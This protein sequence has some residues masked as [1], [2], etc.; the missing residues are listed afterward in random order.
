MSR[1][2]LIL[3]GTLASFSL[4]VACSNMPDASADA[5]AT[6]VSAELT[7]C[8]DRPS[9]VSSAAITPEQFIEPLQFSDSRKSAQERLRQ[10][11]QR[12]ARS[13]ITLDKPGYMVVTVKSEIFGFTDDMEFLFDA[14]KNVVHFRSGARMGYYDF[15]VN[16]NRMRAITQEFQTPK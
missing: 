1:L 5:D 8:P 4:L 13:T 14:K 11:I 3:I 12:L 9:C 6:T 16:R 15:G 7:P 2:S 10:I